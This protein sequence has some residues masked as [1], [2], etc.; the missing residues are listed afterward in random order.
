MSEET[1]LVPVHDVEVVDLSVMRAPTEVVEEA[2]KAASV[3]RDIISKKP[4]QVKFNGRQYLEF[5]DWQTVGR[6]YGLTARVRESKYIEYGE[7]K[8]FEAT[9]EAVMVS[10]GQVVSSAD[11]MCLN[12][13]KNWKGRELNK[14][15]SMAQTRACAKVLRNVLS[16]V[17]VLAGYAPTPAEEID[18]EN[19][20]TGGQPHGTQ[21]AAD[22]VRDRKVS[23]AREEPPTD[24]APELRKYLNE[25]PA[26]GGVDRCFDFIASE[27]EKAGGKAEHSAHLARMQAFGARFDAKTVISLDDLQTQARVEWGEL[28]RIRGANAVGKKAADESLFAVSK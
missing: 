18:T 12:D 27:I 1:A 23:Q 5:E 7:A 10:T 6:F 25:L 2:R 24:L 17:V 15:R 16:W 28:T 3:L 21:A 4:R 11:A 20:D 9:A 8:G 26:K 14:L 22:A 19:I 13:E